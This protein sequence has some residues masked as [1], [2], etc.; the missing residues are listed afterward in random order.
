MSQKTMENASIMTR[1]LKITLLGGAVLLSGC[2]GTSVL[3][4]S[5]WFTSPL[6]WF[7]S[8]LLISN[9]GVGQVTSMT[10]MKM[11]IVKNQLD[12]RYTMR[13]GMQ[14]ENGDVVTIFQGIDDE[15]VKIE[16]IGPEKGYVS[17]IIVSD[18]NVVT[19]WDTKIG[20]VFSDIYDKAFGACVLGERVNDIA[21]VDCT[22]KQSAKVVYRFSGKWHGPENLMPADDDLKDWQVVQI[23]WT[24]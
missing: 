4:P 18:P 19:E 5:T 21:T 2:A 1:I 20:S 12:D 13:S 17:R 22:A 11:D 10:P 15:Q 3:S 23:I 7:S 16:V 8:P 9:S 6:T 14:M 24:K